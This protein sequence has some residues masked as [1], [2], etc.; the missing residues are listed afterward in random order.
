MSAE[1]ALRP[2]LRC[3]REKTQDQLDLQALHR[4]TALDPATSRRPDKIR[5]MPRNPRCAPQHSDRS[6]T[7]KL[8]ER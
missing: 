6:Y 3:V 8:T 5:R 1:A 7:R 2:N 4:V